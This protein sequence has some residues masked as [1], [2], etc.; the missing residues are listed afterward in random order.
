M[1]AVAREVVAVKRQRQSPWQSRLRHVLRAGQR[2]AIKLCAVMLALYVAL[3]YSPLLTWVARPLLMDE[4]PHSAQALLVFSGDGDPGYANM[5]YQRRA[6]ETRELFN[7]GWAPRVIVSSGKG[8]VMSEARVVK[9]LLMSQGLPPAAVTALDATPNGTH[10]H[11]ESV[12]RYLRAQG[13]QSV[14]LV[15]GPYHA[16]RAALVWRRVAPDIQ[17]TVVRTGG[18]NLPD[19]DEQPRFKIATLVAYEYAALIYYWWNN[20]T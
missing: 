15:T 8:Q 7:R 12:A 18:T 20:W 5:G 19:A 13:C 4:L 3:V 2:R 6:N 11:I 16:W 10:A 14:L 17:V 1:M 9:A